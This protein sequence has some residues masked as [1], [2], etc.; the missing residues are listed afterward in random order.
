[1]P[2]NEERRRSVRYKLV[3]QEFEIRDK[4]VLIVDD[5]IVRGNT[6][7][8]I[9]KMV[10]EFG[11]KKIF[12]ISACQPV[13]Y[14]CYYG[15]DIPTRDELTAANKSVEEIKEFIGVD[16]LMYQELEDLKEAVTRKGDHNIDRPCMA[17][18]DGW[19]VT[20]DIDEKTM[21]NME[22]QRTT[23]RSQLK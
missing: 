6:S 21:E 5:S 8:E 18:L 9:V 20:G 13:R 7:R 23:E 12:F 22:A 14:P 19:Y 11:A 3:P 1:M 4:N 15:V 17:C 16:I 2:G 10:R